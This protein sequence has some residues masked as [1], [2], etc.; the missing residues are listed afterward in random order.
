MARTR[1]VLVPTTDTPLFWQEKPSPPPRLRVRADFLAAAK[2]RRRHCTAFVLQYVERPAASHDVTEAPRVGF[3]V[4]RKVGNAVVRNRIRRRLRAA[5]A[6]SAGLPFRPGHDY[7][8]VAR[9]GALTMPFV[10]LQRELAHALGSKPARAS[11][12][13][14]VPALAPIRDT[15]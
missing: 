8:L 9:L 5:V 12:G 1:R 15:R 14:A 3:T 2:G 7:V 13:P 4:T 10:D 6:A 11:Q